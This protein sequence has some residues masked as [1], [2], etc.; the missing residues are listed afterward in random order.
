MQRPAPS[1]TPL[2]LKF[3]FFPE[4]NLKTACISRSPG[5]SFRQHLDSPKRVLSVS[6][7]QWKPVYPALLRLPPRAVPTFDTPLALDCELGVLGKRMRIKTVLTVAW[8]QHKAAL[9][10]GS[11]GNGSGPRSS[12]PRKAHEAAQVTSGLLCL[13]N[14]NALGAKTSRHWCHVHPKVRSSQLSAT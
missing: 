7:R 1:V 2:S 9:P 3:I 6:I 4:M 13:V 11:W 12:S 8:A 10:M 14:L 5:L